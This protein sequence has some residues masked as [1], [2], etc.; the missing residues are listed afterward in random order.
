ME[1]SLQQSSPA[2]QPPAFAV[3]CGEQRLTRDD[4]LALGALLL[5]SLLE[6]ASLAYTFAMS[7]GQFGW[8]TAKLVPYIE[9]GAI[10][11]GPDERFPAGDPT[12]LA[13]LW[14]SGLFSCGEVVMRKY[15]RL[16]MMYIDGGLGFLAR[17]RGELRSSRGAWSSPSVPPGLRKL[18]DTLDDAVLS[19]GLVRVR[20]PTDYAIR[21]YRKRA[22]ADIRRKKAAY[23]AHREGARLESEG[24]GDSPIDIAE[25]G[26]ADYDEAGICSSCTW[27]QGTTSLLPDTDVV[28]LV[29]NTNEHSYGYGYGHG[30]DYDYGYGSEHDEDDGRP[31]RDDVPGE[32][33]DRREGSP[34]QH[35]RTRRRCRCVCWL[36][37]VA[38]PAPVRIGRVVWRTFERTRRISPA[39]KSFGCGA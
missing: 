7:I 12:S 11:P 32:G 2:P 1:S 13:G 6:D 8:D 18:L 27:V 23:D 4:V 33:E 19:H 16:H 30:Y 3:G 25:Y 28:V 22:E 36:R 39:R 10:E 14:L 37:G 5:R 34:Q 20:A 21:L 9:D 38:S 29:A 26:L 24:R 31:A 15:L 35:L 17:K